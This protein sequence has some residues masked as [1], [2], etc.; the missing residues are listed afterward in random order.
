[1]TWW[2]ALWWSQQ[3]LPH[4]HLG[5]LTIN[6]N[7]VTFFLASQ[8]FFF[9]LTKAIKIPQ[10]FFPPSPTK[11]SLNLQRYN[12]TEH[13]CGQGKHNMAVYEV[14]DLKQPDGAVWLQE[15]IPVKNAL[16]HIS[17][18]WAWSE[19]CEGFRQWAGGGPEATSPFDVDWGMTVVPVLNI[20]FSFSSA[21]LPNHEKRF[22]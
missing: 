6:K 20:K 10:A 2:F 14:R 11:H 3:R 18:G 16:P 22:L 17:F 9:F 12:K 5:L 1:M 8:I 13:Q 7:A 4:I 15:L 21:F 19:A